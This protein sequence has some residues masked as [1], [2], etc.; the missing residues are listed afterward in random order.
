MKLHHN[1]CIPYIWIMLE[2]L[3]KKGLLVRKLRPAVIMPLKN[4]TNLCQKSLSTTLPSLSQPML[5]TTLTLQC[6]PTAA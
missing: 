6:A 3:D 4:Q 1:P 5:E 2:N